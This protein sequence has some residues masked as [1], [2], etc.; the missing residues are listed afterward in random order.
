MRKFRILSVLIA[1]VMVLMIAV[2]TLAC[3]P[4]GTLQGRIFRSQPED[5]ASGTWQRVSDQDTFLQ[6]STGGYVMYAPFKYRV[7]IVRMSDI[8]NAVVPWQLNAG[9]YAN[10]DTLF[11]A[12]TWY[13]EGWGTKGLERGFYAVRLVIPAG[14]ELRYAYVANPGLGDDHN[15]LY[16]VYSVYT[17][18]KPDN[19]VI[20]FYNLEVKNWQALNLWF[21]VFRLT[22]G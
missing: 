21:A 11:P 4:Q 16:P 19:T 14:W 20:Y 15:G 2:P 7:D 8:H 9:R 3:D 22:D 6:N 12:L 10:W 13:K 17:Q 5:K 1:V 18:Y